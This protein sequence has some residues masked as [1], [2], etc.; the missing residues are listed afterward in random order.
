MKND[1]LKEYWKKNLKY[2]IILTSIWFIV[3]VVMPILLVDVLNQIEIAGFQLGFWIAMQG[4]ITF[5]VI[6]MF[7]YVHLMNKLDAAYGL[8]EE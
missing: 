6:L 1:P 8:E 4:A 3:G 7:I 5:F 2:L